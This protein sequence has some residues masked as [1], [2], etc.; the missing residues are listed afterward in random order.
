[1][2]RVSVY[3]L[4]LL[5]ACLFGSCQSSGSERKVGEDAPVFP[6]YRGVTIPANIAPL[7][8]VLRNQPE[9]VEVSLQG[10]TADFTVIGQGEKV[11]F[12]SR[13][14]RSLLEKERGNRIRVQVKALVGGEWLAYEPFVWQVARDDA[15]AFLT[16]R[17]T[18]VGGDCQIRERS[19]ADFHERTL[20]DNSLLGG[21]ALGALGKASP[22]ATL[23]AFAYG[24]RGEGWVV[25]DGGLLRRTADCPEALR[26]RETFAGD[27]LRVFRHPRLSPDG[28]WLLYTVCPADSARD[29]TLARL[30]RCELRLMRLSDGRI[31][32]LRAVNAGGAEPPYGWASGSRWFVFSS[33]RDDGFYQKP[34]ICHVDSA[35]RAGKPFLLPMREPAEYD[36]ALCSFDAPEFSVARAPF[37]A[38]DV[39]ALF[40]G[41]GAGGK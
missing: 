10:K 1:M 11:Q 30:P 36:Y 24:A 29:S 38:L 32:S 15:D 5:A 37:D 41:A 26:R 16:Y 19:V 13:E 33:K 34:Y 22:G 17:R 25:S 21:I 23:A 4:G 8:F 31:D 7:N 35:G 9:R 28:E 18:D 6:D 3:M 2:K 40:A 12:P 39:E 20:A 27:T 14:W